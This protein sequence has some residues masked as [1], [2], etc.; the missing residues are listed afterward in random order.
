ML[1]KRPE[2]GFSLI[3]LMVSMTIGIF[4]L[5]G[6]TTFLTNTLASN[7]NTFKMSRVNQEMRA[8]MT[9]MVRDIRRAGYWGSPSYA[10]GALSG[11]SSGATYVNPFQNLNTATGGC[12]LYR[13]DKNGNGSLDSNE[14]F[15][16]L[17]S[18]GVIQ[19]Y[20][21]TN[22]T[23]C[24]GGTGWSPLTYVKNT[25]VTMLTFTETDSA[26]LY[27][28]GAT[29][30]NIKVRYIAITLTAQ[31]ATD[32]TVSQTLRETVKLENDLFSPL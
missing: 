19:M 2:R 6:F 32:A 29:G 17:L 12:I 30:P 22:V 9:L 25:Q 13:Y 4:L 16:F 5:L 18:S 7:A 14:Y 23:T 1:K 10:A 27:I 24:T 21:G 3:E 8:V 28:N 26:P 20:D 15:G 31:S 11:V